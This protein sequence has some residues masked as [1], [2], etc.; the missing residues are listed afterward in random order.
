[1]TIKTK[2]VKYIECDGCGYSINTDVRHT[3]LDLGWRVDSASGTIPLHF[4]AEGGNQDC[5]R[6]WITSTGIIERTFKELALPL[7]DKEREAI[8]KTLRY[9]ANAA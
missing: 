9:R 6:Y 8:L 4:H 2:A 5:L 7:P 1:M 3:K